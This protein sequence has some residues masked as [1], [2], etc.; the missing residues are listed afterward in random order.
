MKQ[1]VFAV[2]ENL[3][4]GLDFG[5][6]WDRIPEDLPTFNKLTQGTDLVMGRTTYES[7]PFKASAN[8]QFIVVS[9]SLSQPDNSSVI[10]LR[11]ENLHTFL[12]STGRNVSL[13][14]GMSLLTEENLKLMDKIYMTE[15]RGSFDAD[16]FIP[17]SVYN[18]VKSKE[19]VPVFHNDKAEMRLYA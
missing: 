18:F 19:S 2:A 4:F 13:I 17:Q 7:L 10:V 14:G 6:P 11:P 1:A 3:A 9:S 8:R 16:V 15:V 5:L 12:R